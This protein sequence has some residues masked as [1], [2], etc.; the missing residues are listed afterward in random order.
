[1]KRI[2]AVA[3]KLVPFRQTYRFETRFE[4]HFETM[5]ESERRRHF[6]DKQV[7]GRTNR[8]FIELAGLRALQKY[9]CFIELLAGLRRA[10]QKYQLLEESEL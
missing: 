9:H 1:M 4:T 3:T 5:T 10:L 2:E 7:A 6:A 8:C